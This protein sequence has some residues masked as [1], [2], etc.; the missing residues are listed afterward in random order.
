MNRKHTL[1]PCG[2]GRKAD[3]CCL[4]VISGEQAAMSPEQLMRSRYTAYAGGN[5]EYI[6]RSWHSSTRPTELNLDNNVSWTGL[7]V[8][9]K[10]SIERA[11]I[12]GDY[13]EFIASYISNGE[14]GQMHERSRF[15]REQGEWRYVDGV[16]I[17]VGEQLPA[18]VPGRNDPCFCGSGKKFKKCCGER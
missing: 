3:I 4:P 11:V 1:C 10:T 13:V 7:K 2:S 14:A 16:Q 5:T 6:L 8:L 12:E 18:K 17:E 15:L 9:N